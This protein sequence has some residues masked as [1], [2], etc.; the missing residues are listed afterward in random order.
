MTTTVVESDHVFLKN[1]TLFKIYFWLQ[2]TTLKKIPF[3]LESGSRSETPFL[4]KG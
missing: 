2:T 1:G 4:A 3:R